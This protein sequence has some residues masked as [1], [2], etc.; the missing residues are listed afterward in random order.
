ML[1]AQRTLLT[2]SVEWGAVHNSVV[3]TLFIIKRASMFTST[4]GLHRNGQSKDLCGEC[5]PEI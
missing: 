3:I 4:L 2:A 5:K 1:P